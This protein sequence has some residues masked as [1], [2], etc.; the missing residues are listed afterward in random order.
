MPAHLFY[1]GLIE[2]SKS[3]RGNVDWKDLPIGKKDEKLEL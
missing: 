1:N 3:N 2:N